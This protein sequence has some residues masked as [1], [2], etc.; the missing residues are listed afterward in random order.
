MKSGAMDGPAMIG[1]PTTYF[2]TYSTGR[3]RELAPH[4]S[5]KRVD[6]SKLGARPPEPEQKS[7]RQTGLAKQVWETEVLEQLEAARRLTA[8]LRDDTAPW[9]A[10]SCAE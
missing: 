3:L 10:R 2:D 7:V 1:I 5:L 6:L 8:A 9:A 4:L